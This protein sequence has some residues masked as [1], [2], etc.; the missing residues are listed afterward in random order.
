VFFIKR[1][2]ATG[3][4]RA[5]LPPSGRGVKRAECGSHGCAKLQFVVRRAIFLWPS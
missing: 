2:L 5:F 4:R 3:G 1:V